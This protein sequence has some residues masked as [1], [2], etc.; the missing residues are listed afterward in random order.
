MRGSSCPHRAK[1]PL[2]CRRRK[3]EEDEGEADR[4][5][6]PQEERKK[7]RRKGGPPVVLFPSV[8]R[9]SVRRQPKRGG[10]AEI[11]NLYSAH[12]RRCEG[13]RGRPTEEGGIWGK[14]SA[15]SVTL[16]SN[17]EGASLL[18]LFPQG[19][20]QSGGGGGTGD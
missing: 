19:G 10:G 5:K 1:P 2:S 20:P 4:G 17:L 13:T 18:Q 12:R 14:A 16:T 3:S 15:D 9:P 11:S 6:E 7:E 8:R